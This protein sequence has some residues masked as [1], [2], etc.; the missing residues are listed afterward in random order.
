MR[1]AIDDAVHSTIEA[2]VETFLA[3]P[4]LFYTEH[5]LV[6]WFAAE[7]NARLAEMGE[8]TDR[9]GLPHRLVHAEYPTPFR[10]DMK[11]GGFIPK[12]ED[13]RTPTGGKYR[14]GH[15]DIAVLNPKFIARH[16]YQQLKAQ[17]FEVFTRDVW[18][19]KQEGEPMLLHAI[20]FYLSR[21][22][23]KL[24]RGKDRA[25]GAKRCARAIL[26]DAKKVEEAARMTGFVSSTKSLA[27]LKGTGKA[28]Q[29]MIREA[30][31]ERPGIE[32]VFAE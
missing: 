2:L 22:E 16:T 20:E 12:T 26:Q 17:N 5:D 3:K 10:C 8:V 11:N 18:D 6:I 9:D 23:I 7:L 4:T 29:A 28:V 25:A 19:A 14:R 27:F 30:V 21:D 1:D 31:G 24:S 32:L 13:D 15:I